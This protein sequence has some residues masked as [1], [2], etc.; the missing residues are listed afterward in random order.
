MLNSIGFVWNT[1]DAEWEE[2]FN[3]LVKYKADHGHTK[4]PQG[5]WVKNQRDRLGKKRTMRQ[6]NSEKINQ[7]INKLDSL[8][9]EW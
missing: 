6:N 4:V 1:Y 8:G 7:R 3:Q 9:F 5:K 2:M